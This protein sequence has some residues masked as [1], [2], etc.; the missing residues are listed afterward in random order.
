MSPEELEKLVALDA[1]GFIM[2]GSESAEEFLQRIGDTE[3]VYADFEVKLAEEGKVKVF[4]MFEVS[5]EERISPELSG[6]A[7]E[8]TQKL[9]GFTVSHVPGFYLT[10]QIGIFWGGCLI[11]DPEENF[12]VFLLRNV[13]RKKRKFLNYCR[14]ELLAH[15]LCH[16]VRH[17]LNEPL[18]EEYFAY[19][20][21]PSKLRRYLGNCFIS[22]K[23]AWGFLLPVMLLPLAEIVKAL[24]IHDFPS[25]I[26]WLAAWVYPLFLLWRNHCSRR[27]VNKARKALQK[28][29]VKEVD[30]VLFRIL[31]GEMREL[32]FCA[33]EDIGSLVDE[34]AARYDRWQVIRERFFKAENAGNNMEVKDE[35]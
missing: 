29:G 25:W 23:D 5:A 1:A 10:R 19:Q 33:P 27:V 8:I 3:K 18:L 30:A 34:K 31:P 2:T 11:G 21:S 26:F 12:A 17:I 32:S 6:E 7:A 22:D 24:W 4:D 16:S 15:E 14:E 20:T 28:A 13:F 35:N 9:Y